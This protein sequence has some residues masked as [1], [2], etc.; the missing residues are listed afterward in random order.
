MTVCLQQF[1]PPGELSINSKNG[2]I[3]RGTLTTELQL[4]WVMC[5]EKELVLC[6]VA[7]SHGK[8]IGVRVRNTGMNT[9]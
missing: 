4:S 9:A 3:N 7:Y 2:I 5:A 1:L 6:R 8:N